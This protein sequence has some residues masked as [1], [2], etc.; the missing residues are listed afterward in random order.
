MQITLN[1]EGTAL[2]LRVANELRK[3]ADRLERGETL[4]SNVNSRSDLVFRV[5]HF[6]YGVMESVGPYTHTLNIE[7]INRSGA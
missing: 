5:E 2:S 3:L 4:V 1:E 7:Y 6:G